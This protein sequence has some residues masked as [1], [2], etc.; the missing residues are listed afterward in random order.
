MRVASVIRSSLAPYYHKGRRKWYAR[1]TYPIRLADGTI[2]RR[3]GYV[4]AGNDTRSACQV[5]CDRLNAELEAA[6]R[7]TEE[8]ITFARAVT[9]YVA[10][11]HEARFLHPAIISKL[12]PI[13]C[14]AITA[15]MVA[16]LATQLYPNAKP[17]T[18]NRQLYT[19]VIAVLNLAAEGKNWTPKIRLSLIHI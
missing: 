17:S 12:G 19:P 3:R 4:G 6:A 2:E 7:D 15:D 14:R 9:T 8:R 18:I 1:G 5:E 11:G 10:Q 16:D 13:D